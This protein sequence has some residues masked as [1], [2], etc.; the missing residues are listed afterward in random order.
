MYRVSSHGIFFINQSVE[1]PLCNEPLE[2]NDE[3]DVKYLNELQFLNCNATVFHSDKSQEQEVKIIHEGIKHL[4]GKRKIRTESIR[5]QDDEKGRQR[6]LLHF[7][8]ER[9]DYDLKL[10]FVT[11]NQISEVGMTRNPHMVKVNQKYMDEYDRAYESK[12]YGI[13]YKIRRAFRMLKF[14]IMEKQGK[15]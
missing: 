9:P 1:N 13:F 2:I 7:Y 8:K 11:V 15:I 3:E 5:I 10:S 6:D 4:T 14:R 12:L